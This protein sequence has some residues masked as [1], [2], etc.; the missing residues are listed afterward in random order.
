MVFDDTCN[1]KGHEFGVYG[2][3]DYSW[4]SH[5]LNGGDGARYNMTEQEAVEVMTDF[6]NKI[7]RLNLHW[8]SVEVDYIEVDDSDEP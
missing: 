6:R 3:D 5:T 2:K 8:A 7:V 1:V 4:I